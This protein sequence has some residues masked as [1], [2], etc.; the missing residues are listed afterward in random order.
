MFKLVNYKW[1]D[2]F[3]N[4]ED[5]LESAVEFVLNED[6]YGDVVG[7]VNDIYKGQSQFVACNG[8]YTDTIMN[9]GIYTKE[10][11]QELLW[12]FASFI[13]DWNSYAEK[14]EFPI[15]VEVE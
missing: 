15:V 4:V 9:D 10:E 12:D 6:F 2:V 13:H 7:M 14:H 5:A 11:I 3:E 8:G 1:D